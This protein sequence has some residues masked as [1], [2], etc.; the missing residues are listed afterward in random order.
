MLQGSLLQVHLL[1]QACPAVLAQ[2]GCCQQRRF[3]LLLLLLL[4]QPLGLQTLPA[5]N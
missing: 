3:E 2:Q 4:L 5:Q 1:L